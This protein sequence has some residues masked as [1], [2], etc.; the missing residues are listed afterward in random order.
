[1]VKFEVNVIDKTD[2]EKVIGADVIVYDDSEDLVKKISIV[3]EN[4][5]EE[6]R[7]S[8]DAVDE[9]YLKIAELQSEV[10]SL[11]NLN[12]TSLQGNTASSF[13]KSSHSHSEYAK[14]SHA[15][16]DST[17]GVGTDKLYGH[18]KTVNN[19]TTSTDVGGS[20]LSAYQGKVLN[21]A[22]TGIKDNIGVVESYALHSNFSLMK[23]GQIV[24][25]V[26][27]KWTSG[28]NLNSWTDL[29]FNNGDAQIPDGYK[30][31][32]PEFKTSYD[33]EGYYVYYGNNVHGDG[34]LRLR[35]NAKTNTLQYYNGGTGGGQVFDGVIIWV[36]ED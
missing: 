5:L 32:R 22:I 12:A 11:T 3:D 8:L 27:T 14:T 19:L 18:V 15:S 33:K 6:L 24:V 34:T 7:K 9:T 31:V 25:C 16:E 23:A 35:A 36:T 20:A 30:P 26:V 17:Y 21:D 29:T 2:T 4:S 10:N 1:M 28:G 13:A